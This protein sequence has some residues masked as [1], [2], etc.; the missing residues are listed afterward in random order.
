MTLFRQQA[1]DHFLRSSDGAV[2][3]V[4][5]LPYRN[6]CL[7]IVFFLLCLLAFL[8]WG[9]YAQTEVV[10][11]VLIPAG[12]YTK[13]FSGF[14]GTAEVLHVLEGDRVRRGDVLLTL[15]RAHSA[16]LEP[17]QAGGQR[18]CYRDVNE[19]RI[20]QIARLIGL[21]RQRI[22]AQE[23]LHRQE[24][25]ALDT[26]IDHAQRQI[27][28]AQAQRTQQNRDIALLQRQWSDQQALLSDAHVSRAV[29]DE[30]E[31]EL[32]SSRL[33]LSVID[34]EIAEL[35]APGRAT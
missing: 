12:G 27:R 18:A 26:A 31:R 30:K 16:C 32:L 28:L 17:V 21:Q 14:G 3:Q 23:Q 24:V 15:R 25:Q 19:G 8:R 13:V 7:F 10:T 29:F 4:G 6:F 20:E 9:R 34:K 35:G 33:R 22:A 1:V 2:L 5:R 11:G